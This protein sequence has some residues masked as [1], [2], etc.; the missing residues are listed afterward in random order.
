MAA[1]QSISIMPKKATGRAASKP[2]RRTPRSGKKSKKIVVEKK[3]ESKTAESGDK[4]V[5][6]RCQIIPGGFAGTGPNGSF[7]ESPEW[8]DTRKASKKVRK[9]NMFKNHLILLYF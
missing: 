1:S 8:V 4:N 2:R 9:L 5:G 6:K 7:F 3:G